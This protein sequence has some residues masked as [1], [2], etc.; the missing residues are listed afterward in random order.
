MRFAV[1][2]VFVFATQLFAQDYN[3]K[4]FD[5]EKGDTLLVGYCTREVFDDSLFSNWFYEEYDFYKPEFEDIN[6][7]QFLLNDISITIVMGTWCSD[8]RE[9]VPAFYK[10]MDELN[11][12]TG[13]ITLI[14]VDRKKQ[15]Q[16]DEVKEL[17][18]KFVP[19]FIIYRGAVELG[20]II[21]S[22]I[23][24]IEVDLYNILSESEK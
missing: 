15:S 18:I 1:I 24:T 3:K 12:D 9:V 19:T 17:D 4:I 7:L 5:E 14:N 21:E 2:L 22:P 11:Y 6:Q 13:N 20:R 23:E 10:T 16:G 8:S